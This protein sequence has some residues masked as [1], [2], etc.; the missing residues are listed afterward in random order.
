MRGKP[1][2]PLLTTAGRTSRSE[3]TQPTTDGATKRAPNR[4]ATGLRKGHPK[5]TRKAQK[6]TQKAPKRPPKGTPKGRPKG[7][8]KALKNAQER[9]TR[10]APG[11]LQQCGRERRPDDHPTRGAELAVCARRRADFELLRLG[12]TFTSSRLPED[13][14]AQTARGWQTSTVSGAF[15]AYDWAKVDTCGRDFVKSSG[16]RRRPLQPPGCLIT[17]H[18][19]PLRVTDRHHRGRGPARF[20]LPSWLCDS[21]RGC[22]FAPAHY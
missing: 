10:A 2:E 12:P 18:T 21:K 9:A 8:Q 16:G 22:H 19:V 1:H 14:W 3:R 4:P 20:V 7:T 13:R 17:K 15:G 5:G 6:G 11:A